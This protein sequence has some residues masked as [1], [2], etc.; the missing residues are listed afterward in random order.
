MIII[1]TLLSLLRIVL[2]P[3]FVILFWQGGNRLLLSIFIF[4]IAALTDAYDGYFARRY[5]V[6]SSWGAFLDPM[7]DKVL[8]C[9]TLICL[10]LKGLVPWWLVCVIMIRDGVVTFLRSNAI[11]QGLYLPTTWMAKCKTVA[12]F[13]AIYTAFLW[14]VVH[15]VMHYS[16][17]VWSLFAL[18]IVMY[19]VGALTLYTGVDYVRTYLQLRQK[20]D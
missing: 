5:G 19:A 11:K 17:A 2:T 3:V 10:V 18:R 15:E 1:P 13:V 4:T 14:L 12:Q 9:T 7:A 16:G 20:N 8:I 6:T